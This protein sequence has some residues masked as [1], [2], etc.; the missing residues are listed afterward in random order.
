MI[1]LIVAG[2]S[3]TR[4]W[5]LSTPEY[6]KHLL[7]IMGER[8]LLQNTFERAKRITSL[9]K[10]YISTEASH[11]DYVA[12]QLPE[13]PTSHVIVEPARRD[14][15]PCILNAIQLISTRHPH[16]E[17]IASI[18]ADHHIRDTD[19]FVRAITRAG[20][21][22]AAHQRIC[23]LGIEP[24]QPDTK[25]GYIHKDSII[26]EE[27]NVYN[28]ESF[29]E[30]PAYSV[31]RR[32]FESGEYFWN[33]GYF[34]APYTV[35]EEA[36]AAHA[37]IHWSEQ[38][39]RLKRAA[40]TQ[41]R[42]AIYLDF[43]KQAIDTALMERVPNLLVIP[44]SFDWMDVGSFDDVYR[45]SSQDHMG[46]SVSGDNVH[47]IDSDHVYVRNGCERPV[48]VIGLDNVTVVNTEHGLL[49]MRTDK[50]QKVRDAV[51]M[52]KSCRE[53]KKQ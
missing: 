37:P 20:R 12:E 48:A 11:S 3:G 50:S 6:P 34:V 23:L 28:I 51:A 30:K 38:L 25:Y 17:P 45:M 39:D 31:A 32:Y 49:V 13:L 52:V 43:Q 19:G 53:N 15:M 41:D 10:I 14:T 7:T 36:I 21:L 27:E 5:P 44:S 4:L 47:I 26:D 46:N 2:G 22:A 18:H 40:N 1:V 9:D 42:D 29:K 8:S 33:A 35:F 16:D 24:Y